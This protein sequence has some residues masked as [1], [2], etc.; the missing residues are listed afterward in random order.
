MN[1]GTAWRTYHV[2]DVEAFKHDGITTE[3]AKVRRDEYIEN[4][5]CGL[6]HHKLL[7][8]EEFDLRPVQTEEERRH[9]KFTSMAVIVHKRCVGR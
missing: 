7:E 9:D 4:T 3:Q 1:S 2:P 5:R 8:G 6:C